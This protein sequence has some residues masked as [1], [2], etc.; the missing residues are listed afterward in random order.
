M[1]RRKIVL[2]GFLLIPSVFLTACAQQ[3][4]WVYKSNS[5]DFAMPAARRTAVVL[6]FQDQR[7]NRNSNAYACYMIPLFPFG[8]MNFDAPEGAQM[9]AT[10]G[11]WV[12]YKPTEDFA[13]ALAEDLSTASIFEDVGFGY[14][15]GDSDVVFTGKILNTKY[16][17]KIL[18]YG[19]SVYGPIFWLFG[20]PAATLSNELSLELSCEDAKSGNVLFSKTYT[21]PKYKKVAWIYSL[22]NDFNYPTMIRAI[23]KDFVDHVGKTI[24][25]NQ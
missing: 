2:L 3:K 8:W 6:P 1:K 11:L 21:A 9:H 4:A 14:K 19:L 7:E 20:A 17:G 12:N 5:F 16:K 22:P 24:L 23:Y 15:K 13:K 18:S 25:R 10:S